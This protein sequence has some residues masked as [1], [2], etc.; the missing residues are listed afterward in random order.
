MTRNIAMNDEGLSERERRVASGKAGVSR[1]RR[2]NQATLVS[3]SR[4]NNDAVL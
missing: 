4:V 3:L 2:H 1:R